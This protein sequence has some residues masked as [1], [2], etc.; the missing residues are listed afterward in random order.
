M[1]F[2]KYTFYKLRFCPIRSKTNWFFL[3]KSNTFFKEE[4]LT[5]DLDKKCTDSPFEISA[6]LLLIYTGTD[7]SAIVS[8]QAKLFQRVEVV[9]VAADKIIIRCRSAGFLAGRSP[10]PRREQFNRKNST[11]PAPNVKTYQSYNNVVNPLGDAGFKYNGVA[12]SESVKSD[13]RQ[14][15]QPMISPRYRYK[16]QPS[17]E[18]SYL[19]ALKHSHTIII[20]DPRDYV[21]T[22]PKIARRE[23]APS[24]VYRADSNNTGGVK[25]KSVTKDA[26]PAASKVSQSNGPYYIQ[27]SEEIPYGLP[28]VTISEFQPYDTYNSPDKSYGTPSKASYSLPLK[29]HYGAPKKTYGE[30]P[31]PVYGEPSLSSSYGLPPTSSFGESPS[32]STSYGVPLSSSY[33]PPSSF[34][35]STNSGISSYVVPSHQGENRGTVCFGERNSSPSLQLF[36]CIM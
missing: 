13:N 3:N 5:F 30:P 15:V 34:S 27:Q 6:V 4:L 19:N 11:N 16:F 26:E 24:P 18:D 17:V 22:W 2:H 20:K 31:L 36:S 25:I 14:T 29:S 28:H 23:H 21:K 12:S 35:S 33:G 10:S 8:L 9:R 32:I 1:I 7:V